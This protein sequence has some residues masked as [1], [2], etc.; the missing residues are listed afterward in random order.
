MQSDTD[1]AEP[2]LEQ[3]P[4]PT[5]SRTIFSA[6]YPVFLIRLPRL[7]TF[8]DLIPVR[9]FSLQLT[10]T[11]QWKYVRC[12]D[13]PEG[14]RSPLSAMLEDSRT[15]TAN[16][17][18]RLR[19]QECQAGQPK[20]KQITANCITV[21]KASFCHIRFLATP[22]ALNFQINRPHNMQSQTS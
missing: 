20:V 21:T 12:K 3:W 17:F 13:K 4:S 7:V 2:A 10:V 6:L 15:L 16:T 8:Q 22:R 18:L 5:L 19:E 11:R 9:L 14:W 1:T